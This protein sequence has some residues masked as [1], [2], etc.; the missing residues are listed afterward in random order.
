MND[1]TLKQV[2]EDAARQAILDAARKII[3]QQ[4]AGTLSMRGLA[5]QVGCSPATIYKYFENKED[6]L[7]AIRQE[8]WRLMSELNLE[9]DQPNLPIMDR[10]EL[11][12]QIFQEFPRRYPEHYLLMFGSIDAAPMTINELYEDRGHQDLAALLQLSMDGGAIRGDQYT[13]RELALLIWFLSHGI[14]MLNLT[15]FRDDEEF[16]EAANSAMLAFGRT[17]LNSSEQ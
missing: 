8:G 2:Q 11:L 3:V 9:Q 13:A 16:M 17:L 1:Q 12:G 6:I 4:G 7:E 10:L 5:K 14:A 15:L